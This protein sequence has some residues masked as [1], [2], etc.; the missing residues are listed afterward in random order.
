MDHSPASG[1]NGRDTRART[2]EE[3]RSRQRSA[4]EHHRW[5]SELLFRPPQANEGTPTIS[6][7]LV[8]LSLG[9][10]LVLGS[11]AAASTIIALPV[12]RP[13]PVTRTQAII[14]A[15]ALRPDVAR[16]ASWPYAGTT[17]PSAELPAPPVPDPVRPDVVANPIA[18]SSEAALAV[19]A[20]FYAL[21]ADDAAAAAELI[22][23]ELIG[24]RADL[25]RAWDAVSATRHSAWVERG[26]A[27][28]AEVEVD[29]PDGH[30]VVLHQRLDV[31]VGIAPR[32]VGAELLRARHRTPSPYRP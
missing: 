30:R 3:L 9:A 10:V 29:Y 15:A 12:P 7:R 28:R 13:N 11:G 32:I 24:D 20:D 18:G 1:S 5:F 14:G 27:V 21:V 2:V 17:W 26:G 22:A 23:P 4:S 31:E 25:V 16:Q 19:V 6:S 8:F